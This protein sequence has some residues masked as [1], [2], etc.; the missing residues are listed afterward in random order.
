MEKKKRLPKCNEVQRCGL[1]DFQYT[2]GRFKVRSDKFVFIFGRNVA[3]D[4]CRN[5][6]ILRNIL[7]YVFCSS[8]LWLFK[9]NVIFLFINRAPS[10]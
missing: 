7:R 1:E 10:C 3:L 5:G 6:K 8:Y 2:R 9:V 4:S